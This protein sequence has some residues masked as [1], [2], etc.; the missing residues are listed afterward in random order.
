MGFR[1]IVVNEHSKLS[2]KNNHLIFKSATTTEL[3]HL[4]EID[5]LILETT[6]IAITS[7]LIAK[8]TEYNVLTIFCDSKRLPITKLMP[9]YGRHDTSLQIKKQL[10]WTIARKSDVWL[11]L[12]YQKICNQRQLLRDFEFDEQARAITKLLNNLELDDPSN[13]EAHAA[14]I[15]F[16]TLFGKDFSREQ[17]NDVNASLNYGYT[18]LMSVFARE[19]VKCGCLT[20]LGVGHVNQFNDFNFASDLMEPFRVLVDEIVYRNKD[21]EFPV[22]KRDLFKLFTRTYSYE[23]AEMYLNNIVRKYTRQMIDYLH[24]ENKKAPEFLK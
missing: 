18:L 24:E 14:R 22:V 21:K 13:R 19:I 5:T 10:D 15:S 9:Y 20:Q 7:M 4:T 8:L 3:I 6:D 11:K 2:Y 12:L 16:N 23:N 1:T 17:D